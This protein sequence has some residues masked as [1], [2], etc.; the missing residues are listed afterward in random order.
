MRQENS[1]VCKK[2]LSYTQF[3]FNFKDNENKF[4]SKFTQ[5]NWRKCIVTTLVNEKSLQFNGI[6]DTSS[7]NDV[8]EQKVCLVV[9]IG[10]IKKNTLKKHVLNCPFLW[11]LSE[12]G[13][14]Y[15]SFVHFCQIKYI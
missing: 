1:T 7:S 13:D 8:S 4:P 10:A 6:Q 11:Y 9:C 5:V 2:I 12:I 14:K 15:L 3:F